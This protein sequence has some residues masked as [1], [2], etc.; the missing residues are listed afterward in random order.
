MPD[1]LHNAPMKWPTLKDFLFQ[2]GVLEN[3]TVEDIV[4]AKKAYR[5]AY[6]KSKKQEYRKAHKEVTIGIPK[7]EV[8]TLEKAAKGHNLTLPQFIRACTKWYCDQVFIVPDEGQ[9]QE[10]CLLLRKIGTNINQVAKIRNTLGLSHDEA[11]AEVQGQVNK[12]EDR[13]EAMFVSPPNLTDMLVTE[14]EKDPR[15]REKLRKILR[16]MENSTSENGHISTITNHYDNQE[17]PAQKPNVQAA[18]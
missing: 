6:L 18:H 16:E 8:L 7:N 5:K 13:I 4:M 15:F 10:L 11:V 9:V 12:L 2:S 1:F 14:A 17:Y 3:G